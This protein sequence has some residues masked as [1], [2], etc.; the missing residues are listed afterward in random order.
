MYGGRGRR[1]SSTNDG[2]RMLQLHNPF[3]SI[4]VALQ[5]G[6]HVP[7]LLQCCQWDCE[8]V[9]P[10]DC[11]LQRTVGCVGFTLPS[12]SALISYKNIQYP[13]SSI[14]MPHPHRARAGFRSAVYQF[15]NNFYLCLEPKVGRIRPLTQILPS[16]KAATLAQRCSD[17]IWPLPVSFSL[18]LV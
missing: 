5:Y 14:I 10:T 6:A 4:D 8:G 12:S 17:I 7:S 11:S 9:T 1:Q 15:L 18:D 2:G 16:H 13:L 3:L